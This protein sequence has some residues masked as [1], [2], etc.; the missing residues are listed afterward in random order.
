MKLQICLNLSVCLGLTFCKH[1][2]LSIKCTGMSA[3]SRDQ[4]ILNDLTGGSVHALHSP[5]PQ[6]NSTFTQNVTYL[7]SNGKPFLK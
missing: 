7:F 3:H 1:M 6:Y 2:R 4:D 5:I